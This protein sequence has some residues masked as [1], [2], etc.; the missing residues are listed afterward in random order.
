MSSLSD[1]Y[2]SARAEFE[3][4]KN[5]VTAMGQF[6]QAVGTK[7][8]ADPDSFYFVNLAAGQQVVVTSAMSPSEGF[9]ATQW[10][11]PSEIMN[12]LAECRRKKTEMMNAWN[13]VPADIRG[14]LV[15]P[16]GRLGPR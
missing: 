16:P 11:Q 5:R 7:I 2:L 10:L 14:G 9:D 6:M 15:P 13:R 3:R 4:A 12:V 1:E 8:V